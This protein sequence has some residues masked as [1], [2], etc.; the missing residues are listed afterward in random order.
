LARKGTLAS[1]GKANRYADD[2]LQSPKYVLEKSAVEVSEP[3]TIIITE[4]KA[5]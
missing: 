2:D 1:I 5:V 4:E 3:P